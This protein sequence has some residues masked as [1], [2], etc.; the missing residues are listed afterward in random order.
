MF[1][2]IIEDVGII[3]RRE[4][5]NGQLQ[6]I[7][8]SKKIRTVKKGS[9]VS[10]DGVCLTVAGKKGNSVMFDVMKETVRKTT[11]AQKKK[12]DRVNIER[13]LKVGDELSGHFVFG[14]VD[15]IGQV[16]EGLLTIKPPR[17]LMKYIVPQGS[18]AIDGVSLTVARVRKESFTVSLVDYTLKHTTL[19]TLKKG[20]MVN[21]EI[22][23]LAKIIWQ[24][25]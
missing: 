7:V 20:D 19:G 17:E 25:K 14:H 4:V 22:D 21:I 15:G 6:L 16:T 12:G 9:S 11:L 2:G 13:A 3:R 23:M 10:V 18:V 24:K 8:E 5:V 1:T